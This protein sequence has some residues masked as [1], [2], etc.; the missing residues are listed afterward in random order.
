MIRSSESVSGD[1]QLTAN[2]P[3]VFL[4]LRL[5]RN[6]AMMLITELGNLFY[7]SLSRATRSKK[8]NP[9]NAQLWFLGFL[10]RLAAKAG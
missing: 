7:I 3:L 4:N 8:K 5:L 2:L 10:Q 1:M 9:T 6:S